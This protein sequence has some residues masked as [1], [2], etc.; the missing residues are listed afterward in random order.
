[1]IFNFYLIDGHDNILALLLHE[2]LL[3]LGHQATLIL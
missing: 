1:M 3:A 2:T